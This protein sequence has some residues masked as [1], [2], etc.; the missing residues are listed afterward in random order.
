VVRY[1]VGPTGRTADSGGER[2]SDPR[3]HHPQK[4]RGLCR[5]PMGPAALA[6]LSIP[7]GRHRHTAH[8]RAHN[9]APRRRTKKHRLIHGHPDSV[10]PRPITQGRSEGQCGEKKSRTDRIIRPIAGFLSSK[11][12]GYGNGLLEGNSVLRHAVWSVAFRG[13]DGRGGSGRARIYSKM[14]AKLPFR[15]SPSLL[16]A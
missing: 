16:C 15:R 12:T 13:E 2:P 9:M 11:V 3:S 7:F 6:P 4:K 5:N 10:P 14:G 1:P 8:P